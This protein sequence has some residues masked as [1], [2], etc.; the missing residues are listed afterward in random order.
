MNYFFKGCFLL[1]RDI[2]DTENSFQKNLKIFLH[3]QLTHL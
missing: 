1:S 3:D 2:T